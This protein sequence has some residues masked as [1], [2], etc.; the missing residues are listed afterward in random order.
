MQVRFSDLR[1]TSGGLPVS[2]NRQWQNLLWI[3]EFFGA[4]AHS[5]ATVSEFNRVPIWLFRSSKLRSLQ[6]ELFAFQRTIRI[7]HSPLNHTR[8]KM[9]FFDLSA[10][11]FTAPFKADYWRK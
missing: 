9:K 3:S 7:Y 4:I 6:P 5:G 2:K 1:F 8:E 11:I 10:K